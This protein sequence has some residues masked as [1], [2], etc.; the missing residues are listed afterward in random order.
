[1]RR[2]TGARFG[3]KLLGLVAVGAIALPAAPSAAEGFLDLYAG[4][5]VSSESHLR[6]KIEG[7]PNVYKDIDL[8]NDPSAGLR[9]GYWFNGIVKWLGLGMDLSYY[10]ARDASGHALVRLH[11]TSLTPT[12]MLR[13]PLLTSEPY[14]NGRLQPYVAGGPAFAL[15]YAQFKTSLVTGNSNDDVND[16]STDVGADARGGLAFHVSKRVA[17]FAEYR[18]TWLKPDIHENFLG[19]DLVPELDDLDAD[20]AL[21]RHHV[22]AGVSFRF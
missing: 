21:R 9:G 5:A 14:P 20:V 3:R 15:T 22:L 10:R 1:M 16:F 11:T 18:F 13:L 4:V 7:A 6:A 8:T 12:L 2:A 19:I 17:L